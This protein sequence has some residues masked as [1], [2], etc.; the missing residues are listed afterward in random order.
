M[1]V[2]ELSGCGDFLSALE[3]AQSVEDSSG[4]LA[5]LH[6]AYGDDMFRKVATFVL[7]PSELELFFF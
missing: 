7:T 6:V 1:Q 5:G 2:H 4:L 3:L